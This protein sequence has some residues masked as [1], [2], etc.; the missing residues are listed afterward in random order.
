MPRS[1]AGHGC[2]SVRKPPPGVGTLLPA[3]ST[4]S[5]SM[6]GRGNVALP[7]FR[8]VAPGKGLIMMAPVWGFPP[9]VPA[10]AAPPADGLPVPAP[11][12]GVDGLADGPEKPQGGQVPPFGI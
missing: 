6:P 2:V 3:S 9:G 4:I 12:L 8:V 7:G 11:S 1:I 5:A 10:G